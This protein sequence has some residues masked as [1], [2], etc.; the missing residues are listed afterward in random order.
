MVNPSF[1]EVAQIPP[2]KVTNPFLDWAICCD[3]IAH[4]STSFP[5]WIRNH[6][7]ITAHFSHP[8]FKSVCIFL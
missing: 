8:G 7:N 5:Y 3:S 6:I 4:T 2:Y 1:D